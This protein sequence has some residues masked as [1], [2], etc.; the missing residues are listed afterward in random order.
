MDQLF[1]SGPKSFVNGI[2]IND[3]DSL[4]NFLSDIYPNDNLTDL[5]NSPLDM[6]KRLSNAIRIFSK[7]NI[8]LALHARVNA[9]QNVQNLDS[10]DTYISIFDGKEY[11]TKSFPYAGRGN[12]DR[13]R[14]SVNAIDL[15]RSYLIKG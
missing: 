13:L 11:M 1:H 15:L 12:P 3:I 10:G 5:I 8:G 4:K 2:V 9:S 14:M 6:A 7:S